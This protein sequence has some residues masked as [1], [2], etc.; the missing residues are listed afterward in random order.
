MCT[1]R[2]PSGSVLVDAYISVPYI[3]TYLKFFAFQNFFVSTNKIL[4][5]F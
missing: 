5:S 1:A 3:C 2:V 4:S